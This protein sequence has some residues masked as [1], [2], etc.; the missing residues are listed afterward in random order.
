MQADT[1]VLGKRL[2]GGAYGN[3]YSAKMR[4][5]SQFVAAIKFSRDI[6]SKEFERET[7]FLKGLYNK[8]IIQFL[9]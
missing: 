6:G 5:N 2:G 7:K 1:F 3:V 4:D 8:N 9:G